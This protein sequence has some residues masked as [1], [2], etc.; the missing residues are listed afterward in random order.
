VAS[1]STAE[2]SAQQ[3]AKLLENFYRYRA[4]A[5]EE[6]SQQPVREFILP[7]KGDASA[8]DKM[9]GV[10]MDQGVEVKR[11]T[12]AFSNGG[13]QYPAGT[14]VIPLAQPS[15]RLIRTLLDAQVDMEEDFLKEQERRR[16]K[17]LPDQIYDIT[18]WSLPLL[19]NVECVA[20][21]APSQGSFEAVTAASLNTGTVKGG[22]ATVA[23][24]VPWGS[25]GARFL[26]SALRH[27]LRV[28]STDK[29][30]KQN[31]QTFD[32]GTLILKVLENQPS[33]HDTVRKLAA[34]SGAEVHAT[35]TG[36][37]DEGVNFGSRFVTH[38]K[39]P[40]VAMA[41]DVP[42]SSG[43]AGHAR[44][45]LER[46]YNYPLTAVRT[47]VLASTDLS[48]FDVIILPDAGGA[49][50]ANVLGPNG[51]RRLREWLSAGGTLIGIG[52]AVSYLADSRVGLLAVSAE[53]LPRPAGAEPPRRA[54]TGGPGGQQ[55]Q[56]PA[57]DARVPGKILADEKAFEAAIQAE[58]EQP[59]TVPGVLVRARLDQ[60][61]WITSGAGET[62]TAMYVGRGIFTPVKLDRGIN[63]GVFL[64][65][66]QLQASGY[67]WKEN[68]QQLAHKP[69]LL[70]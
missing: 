54:E 25:A 38:L 48:R 3:R 59:D 52:G 69:L 40:V 64:G 45:V 36:W 51:L 41:W 26:T 63:A 8:L 12:A 28:H 67:L 57:Q 47:Q 68:R 34:S 1:V 2:T 7:R 56:Q 4:T 19:F 24:L 18:A 46:Q 32:R 62:V 29:P 49:G 31:S 11:A 65:P 30:F 10:L 43:S 42:T 9:A 61:H 37:V 6:G 14:Y 55:A 15:K 27:G 33:I 70:V 44:F 20:A 58:N 16:R 35:N 66:E 50:Y 23:Y 22:P 21:G 53:N 60:D 5:I 13:K 17:K 39:K